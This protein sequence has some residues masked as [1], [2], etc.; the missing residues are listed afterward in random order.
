[1]LHGYIHYTVSSL[2]QL[3]HLDT[4]VLCAVCITIAIPDYMNVINP[5]SHLLE[6]W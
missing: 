2:I 1:M 4:E 5:H 3:L 6:R